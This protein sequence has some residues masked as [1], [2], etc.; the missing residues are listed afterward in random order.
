MSLP[1]LIN[2]T[3]MNDDL[4]AL[5]NIDK[6]FFIPQVVSTYLILLRTKV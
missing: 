5:I 3:K 2:V 6:T 1:R 4:T